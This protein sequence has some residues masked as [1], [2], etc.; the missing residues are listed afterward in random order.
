M[1]P[2]DHPLLPKLILR[3]LRLNCVTEAYANLWSACWSE[4]F[5][6]DAPILPR[7][8]ERPIGPDWTPGTPLRR[9]VDR[10]NTQIEIDALVALML[11]ITAEDLCTIYRTQFAV[12]YGYDQR[13][14]TYDSNGRLIPNSILTL[15]RKLGEPDDP[16]QAPNAD[17]SWRQQSSG[18]IY[19]HPLPFMHFDREA[20]FRLAMREFSSA[21]L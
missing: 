12:L 7:H 8:D 6:N 19:I 5:L 20:D 18:N 16:L 11:N 1:V 15:W 13:D 3:T 21:T 10:R 2:L 4:G 9:A 14:Y 17:Q